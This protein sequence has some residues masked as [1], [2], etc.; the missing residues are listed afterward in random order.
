MCWHNI[1]ARVRHNL[2]ENVRRLPWR[3]IEW[4]FILQTNNASAFEGALTD[5][6]QLPWAW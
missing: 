6:L 2:D 1:K 5:I 3:C 4:V